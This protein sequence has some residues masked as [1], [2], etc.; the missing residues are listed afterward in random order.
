MKNILNIIFIVIIIGSIDLAFETEKQL[1]NISLNDPKVY[2]E[3]GIF[4]VRMKWMIIII[5]ILL[6]S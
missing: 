3:L 4:Q 6:I 5:I 2:L 1:L